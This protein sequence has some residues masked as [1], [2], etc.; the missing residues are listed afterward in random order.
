MSK[1]QFRPQSNFKKYETLERPI[2]FAEKIVKI[3]VTPDTPKDF[4]KEMS[5]YE[6]NCTVV[7]SETNWNP[8]WHMESY[9]N[10]HN[11]RKHDRELE[12]DTA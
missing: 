5:K 11:K 1:P 6:L 3:T 9:Q 8:N 12:R 10:R 2:T 4:L 7:M